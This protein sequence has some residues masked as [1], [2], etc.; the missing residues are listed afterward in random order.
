MSAFLAVDWGST[1][2]R[3]WR[4]D[5]RRAMSAIDLERGVASL[6]PGQAERVFFEEVVPAL[7]GRGLPAIMC[8]MVGSTLGWRTAPYVAAPAGLRDLA[9]GLVEAAPGIRIVPGVKRADGSDVMRGEETQAVGWL[10]ADASRLRGAR[11]LIMPGTHSKHVRIED[12]RIAGFETY[13]TGELF[14]LLRRHSTL[15][16]PVSTWS[17]AAF[18]QGAALGREMG[19]TALFQARARVVSGVLAAENSESFLS[20]ALIGAECARCESASTIIGAPALA[21]LYARVLGG[22]AVRD[23]EGDAA[24]AGLIH[25]HEAAS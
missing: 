7:S 2:L 1:H 11:A 14:E 19:L 10:H 24:L 13:M 6:T 25:I 12:G 15:R 9:A 20:G 17:D 23:E 3:A 22:T 4:V 21:R 8:G 18:D 5:E 16:Q